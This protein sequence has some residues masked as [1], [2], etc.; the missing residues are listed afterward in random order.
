MD[1]NST[2]K[3]MK[4]KNL[5]KIEIAGNLEDKNYKTLSAAQSA[6]VKKYKDMI[7]EDNQDRFEMAIV[8]FQMTAV[9]KHEALSVSKK[10]AYKHR[11]AE[12][13]Y[14]RAMVKEQKEIAKW[15]KANERFEKAEAKAAAKA[16]KAELKEFK[17]AVRE[18]T[19]IAKW[20]KSDKIYHDRM[21]KNTWKEI[22]EIKKWQ[23]YDVAAKKS[24]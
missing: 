23:K 22:A 17:A 13:K 24:A 7:A 12:N 15:E 2:K 21:A 9:E 1:N 10:D 14:H 5:F 3:E 4:M 19:Q 6:S 20:E 18:A 16:V 8:E 11:V